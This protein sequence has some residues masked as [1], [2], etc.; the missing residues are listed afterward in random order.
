MR[1]CKPV[2]RG[3]AAH[4]LH[5]DEWTAVA[6][7]DLEHRHDIRMRELRHRKHAGVI[8]EPDDD[9]ALQLEVARAVDRARAVVPDHSFDPVLL[10]QQRARWELGHPRIQTC[11]RPD[12]NSF[13]RRPTTLTLT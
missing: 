8:P 9:V 3:L 7:A 1:A 5:H 12:R 6:L 2:A 10:G 11:A 4:V 13:W